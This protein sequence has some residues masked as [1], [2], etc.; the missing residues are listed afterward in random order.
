MKNPNDEAADI[1]DTIYEPYI[2]KKITAAEVR[3]STSHIGKGTVL[4]VACGTGRHIIPLA[5]KG[6]TVVGVDS[7][8]GM[9]SVAMKKLKRNGLTASLIQSDIDSF[10]AKN[11]FNGIVCFWN[12]INEIALNEK[13]ALKL[14]KLF[15][16]LLHEHGKAI[17]Q[18]WN[19]K[20]MNF[21]KN[22]FTSEISK[23]NRKYKTTYRILSYN[24]TTHVSH[25]EETIEMI[26]SGKR[27]KKIAARYVHKWWTVAEL[28]KIFK[29][30]GFSVNFCDMHGSK[31]VTQERIYLVA[32][33]AIRTGKRR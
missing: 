19:I 8:R 5:K 20:T 9:L 1:Y 30:A 15:H 18:F 32:E 7:S 14:A 10:K 4:D 23:N 33:K 2:N 17:I 11:K 26:E 22:I 28:R 6:Y 25:D 21:S 29:Q 13:A 27:K 16:R 24:P 3:L 31:N 12:A